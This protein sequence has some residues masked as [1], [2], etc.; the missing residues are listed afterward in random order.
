MSPWH[1]LAGKTIWVAGGAGHLGS[2]IT[3][4]LDREAA[5][6]ICIDMPGKA[7]ALVAREKLTRTIPLSRDLADT[8]TLP[9]FV[10]ETIAAHGVPDGH[11][12]LTYASSSGKR[13]SPARPSRHSARPGSG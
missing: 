11:L 3:R 7:E 12:H 2:A 13:R 8:A 9:A 5:K 10:A 1:S 4:E 6:V